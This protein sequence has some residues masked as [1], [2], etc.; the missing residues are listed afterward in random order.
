M[1]VFWDQTLRNCDLEDKK[2]G[3]E[4]PKVAGVI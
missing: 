1:Q 4:A 2:E 3:F